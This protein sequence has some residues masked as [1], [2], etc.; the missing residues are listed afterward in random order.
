MSNRKENTTEVPDETLT[1]MPVLDSDIWIIIGDDR[2]Q[3]RR[4][5]FLEGM[6]L[7]QECRPLLEEL[8]KVL[9]PPIASE[10]G[11]DYG[12]VM[13]IFAQH[14]TELVRLLGV[15]TGKPEEWVAALDDESG[16]NL[17]MAFWGV[18]YGFFVRRVMMI[19]A[20]GRLTGKEPVSPTSLNS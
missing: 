10:D 12:K 15:S 2:I 19:L 6:R 9:A 5:S 18:N 3:V 7:E 14:A 8:A 4:F 1:E 17:M 13:D 20:P 11:V 16:Y